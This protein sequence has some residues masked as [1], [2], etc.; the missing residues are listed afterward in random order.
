MAQTPKNGSSEDQT[1]G[2]RLTTICFQSQQVTSVDCDKLPAATPE[3][4][5]DRH[6]VLQTTD[7]DKPETSTF[8]Q[9]TVRGAP[10][11][12]HLAEIHAGNVLVFPQ[13]KL[14]R[15]SQVGGDASDA[16]VAQELL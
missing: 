16:A 7:A 3:A 15:V 4:V 8:R 13:S 2:Q 14:C 9:E 6:K 10:E 12:P 5:F 1:P 11:T